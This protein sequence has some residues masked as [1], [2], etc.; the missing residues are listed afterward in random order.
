MKTIEEGSCWCGTDRGRRYNVRKQNLLALQAWRSLKTLLLVMHVVYNTEWVRMNPEATVVGLHLVSITPTRVPACSFMGFRCPIDHDFALASLTL[1][2]KVFL[3]I[4]N[5]FK[6][7][8]IKGYHSS[9]VY[10]YLIIGF[11][12]FSEMFVNTVT[13]YNGRVIVRS[14]FFNVFI[15]KE[16]LI[17][18]KVV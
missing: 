10:L 2:S 4:L 1:I 7:F 17:R 12:H 6:Q 15:S 13:T 3:L 18:F 9:K 5:L 16:L 14:Y 11:M 8:L